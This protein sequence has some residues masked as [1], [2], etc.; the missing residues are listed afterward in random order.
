MP[1]ENKVR[2]RLQSAWLSQELD[3]YISDNVPDN[4]K[5]EPVKAGDK[6]TKTM[7]MQFTIIGKAN[8]L[9]D[10]QIAAEFDK[11]PGGRDEMIGL[12]ID[13]DIADTINNYKGETE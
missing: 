13:Q 9:T 6:L 1:L 3:R 11:F 12:P 10:N 8:G 2:S 5:I 4:G 7:L